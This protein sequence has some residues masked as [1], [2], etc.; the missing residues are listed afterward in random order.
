MDGRL[1]VPGSLPSAIGTV[2]G[3]YVDPKITPPRRPS[4]LPLILTAGATVL[5]L[6]A[7]CCVAGVF[8]WFRSRDTAP[9]ASASSVVPPAPPSPQPVRTTR[10]PL[11][12]AACIVGSWRE[13]SDQSDSVINGVIVR[14]TS[15]GAIQRFT[16]DG[17]N[18]VDLTA[19]VAKTGTQGGNTYT[20]TSTGT[21]TYHYQVIGN[22]IRYSDAQASGTTVWLR[23]GEQFA[24]DQLQGTLGADTFTC[25]GDS[26]IEYGDG[27]S[28]EL[29]RIAG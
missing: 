26:F 14:L 11:T 17:I 1:S 4:S 29:T 16:A 27:Y 20:V 12:G 7:I 13:T 21:L 3:M 28:I 23:D 18:V 25:T 2:L 19:G 6:A 10:P 24:Q 15:S 5:T 22:Q 8:W 9:V